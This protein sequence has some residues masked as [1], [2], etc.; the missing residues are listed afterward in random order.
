MYWGDASTH[1]IETSYLNGTRRRI[2]IVRDSAEEIFF[3]GF[4]LH[5]GNIY[6][7]DWSY[8]YDYLFLLKRKLQYVDL[9]WIC[10]TTSCDQRP[11]RRRACC[12]D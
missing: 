11:K 7:T 3:Y 9:S 5:G 12:V 2:I 10:C 1:I 6:I 4:V 8:P